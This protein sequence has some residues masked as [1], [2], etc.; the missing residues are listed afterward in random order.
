MVQLLRKIQWMR[1]GH[2]PTPILPQTPANPPIY[3]QHGQ[4]TALAA[5]PR[6]PVPR[7]DRHAT[8]DHQGLEN[9]E[10]NDDD[11]SDRVQIYRTAA[12]VRP[13]ERTPPPSEEEQL[14]MALSLSMHEGGTI[15]SSSRRR[16]QDVD[17]NA[18][19]IVTMEES[20]AL[21]QVSLAHLFERQDYHHRRLAQRQ[22]VHLGIHLPLVPTP[23]IPNP[24]LWLRS[25]MI[26]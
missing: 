3:T 20:R 12:Y 15:P 10:N 26:E 1:W 7:H 18:A 23:S 9:G 6:V 19:N 17:L 14:A 25:R 11:F 5:P 21:V 4:D 24:S 8:L 2:L 22:R 13:R 16:R